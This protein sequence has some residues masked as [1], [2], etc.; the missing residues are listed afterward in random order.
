MARPLTSRGPVMNAAEKALQTGNAGHVLIW[1]P[2][3]SENTI[4]NLLEKACCERT[5]HAGAHRQT[6]DRFFRTV[7]HLHCRQCGEHTLD[8]SGKTPEE[9]KT[10]L[11]VESAVESGRFEE[12]GARIPALNHGE[13]RERFGELLKKKQYR[14][15][16]TAPGRRYVSALSDFA[17]LVNTLRSGPRT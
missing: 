12:M 9:K 15:G 7:G 5:L 6:A 14:S 10:I 3:E 8:L 13:V 2:E 11:L 1:I 17:A 16:D 4:K